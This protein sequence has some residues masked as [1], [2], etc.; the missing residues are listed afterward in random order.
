MRAL[1]R[2]EIDPS[3]ADL[4]RHLDLCLGCRACEPA[5]PS[6]VPYGTLIEQARSEIDAHRPKVQRAARKA[7]ADTLAH[8][9]RLGPALALARSAGTFAA[10]AQRLAQGDPAQPPSSVPSPRIGS[11]SPL[12]GI[13]AAR[14]KRRARV[15]MLTGCAMRTLYADINR[16]T[17]EVLAAN[18]C[19]VVINQAQ[20]CC[21]ALHLHSGFDTDAREMARRLIDAF[22]PIDGLDAIV[23]NS[24]GCGS[25]LKE[26]GHLL[27]CDVA[28][29]RKASHFANKCQ[30]FSE[31]LDKLG[32]Y[33]PLKSIGS[34]AT[35]HDACHLAHAQGI[36]AAPRRLIGQIPGLKLVDLPEADI[37]C[38]SAGV[39]SVTEPDMARCL[40]ARK[41]AN[42]VATGASV[43]VAANPGCLSWIGLGLAGLPIDVVHLATLLRRALAQSG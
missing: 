39:Y 6:G 31:F 37:C 27:E 1:R 33:A 35:Y 13:V 34:V 16:D 8:P 42:I 29:S 3:S 15:G 20:Q 5:C 28:Y 2:G 9:Q 41:T 30:D 36:A 26:Y 21:G 19:E 22:G 38:G 25:T 32:L 14:G 11:A 23:V 10:N 40:Q 43:V 7:L 4:R 24:A 18:G 17:A 12:P